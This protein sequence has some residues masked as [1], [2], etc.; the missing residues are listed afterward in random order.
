MRVS[1]SYDDKKMLIIICHDE[2]GRK[3]QMTNTLN[4]SLQTEAYVPIY[5]IKG[6]ISLTLSSIKF[7]NC[8][9]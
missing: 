7:D 6:H 5:A 2:C 1:L 9:S 3:R 4:L 8:I